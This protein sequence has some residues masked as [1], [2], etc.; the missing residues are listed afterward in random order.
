MAGYITVKA[1]VIP[2]VLYGTEVR[3]PGDSILSWSSGRQKE[4]KH[5]SSRL[6]SYPRKPLISGIKAFLPTY[7]TTPIPTLHRE[8]GIPP[9]S[10]LLS[11]IRL[12]HSLRIQT[13]DQ[14]HPMRRR[15]NE[16]GP[17]RLTQT[18][19]LLPK[20]LD[21]EST[22]N[23]DIPIRTNLV[24][25]PANHEI[26][27]YTDGSCYPGDKVGGEYVVYQAQV[28][29]AA[30]GFPIDRRVEL[31]DAEII[32]IHT[33]LMTCISKAMTKFAT[34]FIIYSN[35]KT[36][37][38][39]LGG[40]IPKTSRKEI[41]KIR[42]IQ[43]EWAQ[44]VR[45]AHVATGDVFGQ[46]IPGHSGH[47]TQIKDNPSHLAVEK[48]VHQVNQELIEEWWEKHVPTRYK[49]L[50]I[51][52][53]SSRVCPT[54]LSLPRP[55]LGLLL[56]SRTGHGDFKTYHERFKHVNFEK[57]ECGEDK[58]LE[59]FFFYRKTRRLAR[60]LVGKRRGQE[61]MRLLLRLAEGA[62]AFGRF[63]K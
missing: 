49:T 17:T 6:L 13:L 52:A 14:K 56:A 36:V 34:N 42:K 24:I 63:M 40:K 46:F 55:I 27:L 51:K 26:H 50:G 54:E 10:I 5:R 28:K 7:R 22:E 31:T 43:A 3:W 44:R 16:K 21:A 12:R 2:T 48:W 32:A 38:D 59:H 58:A 39:I 11:G 29:I 23:D 41:Y 1:C 4:L 61:A 37:L 20:L 8:S 35:N 19:N 18:A 33:G 47:N 9:V 45:L 15:A 62:A 53:T 60:K 57:C 30:E 25:Q